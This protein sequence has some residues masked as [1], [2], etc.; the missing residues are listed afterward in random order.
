MNEEI[1]IMTTNGEHTVAWMAVYKG[2]LSAP[3][4]IDQ[5]ELIVFEESNA[6]LDFEALEDT[7]FVL[8]SAVKHPY[9][10]VLGHYSVHTNEEALER[11]EA[12]IAEIGKRLQAAGRL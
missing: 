5:R 4:S 6:A 3:A 2:E 9:H 7:G 12:R 8:G 10:L 1:H 11:G